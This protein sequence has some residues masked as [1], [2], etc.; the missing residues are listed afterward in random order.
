M[1]E[2]YRVREPFAL[3]SRNGVPRICVAGE[4]LAADDPDLKG[5]EQFCEPVASYVER[6]SETASAAPGEVRAVS[7]VRHR[8]RKVVEQP[9]PVVSIPESEL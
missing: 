2:F 1:A 9:A 4:L 8:R 7:S 5:R 3:T 6:V